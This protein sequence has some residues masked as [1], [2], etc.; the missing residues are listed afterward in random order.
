MRKIKFMKLYNFLV[1]YGMMKK[2]KTANA[3]DNK[4]DLREKRC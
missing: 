1:Q 4:N 2:A 3:I